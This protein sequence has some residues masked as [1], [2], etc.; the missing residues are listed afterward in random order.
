MSN[1]I[2]LNEL[3]MRIAQREKKKG[4]RKKSVAEVRNLPVDD[5][6]TKYRELL[7]DKSYMDNAIKEI[8]KDWAEKSTGRIYV[9]ETKK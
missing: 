3:V 4:G 1:Y 5:K 6:I 2:S 7:E 9:P 8:A